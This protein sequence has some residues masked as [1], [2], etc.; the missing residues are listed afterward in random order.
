MEVKE[1]KTIEET[2]DEVFQK[3]TDE[4]IIKQFGIVDCRFPKDN[5][6]GRCLVITPH[7]GS[8]IIYALEKRV[9]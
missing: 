3:L 7:K 8:K 4:K 1:M 5:T 9:K 2:L 6:D